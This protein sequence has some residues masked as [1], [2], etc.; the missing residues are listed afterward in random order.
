MNLR[1]PLHTVGYVVV[2]D[3]LK[4]PPDLIIELQNC[5]H[6]SSCKQSIFNHDANGNGNDYLRRQQHLRRYRRNTHLH[7]I[8]CTLETFIQREFSL[9][10]RIQSPILLMS[11]PGCQSQAP[12]T[13]F[14]T[15]DA[16][17]Q[18]A[19]QEI[20]LSMIVAL[21][22]ETVFDIYENSIRKGGTI[23]AKYR[24]QVRMR[25]GDIIVFRG[26]LVHGGSAYST[27]NVRLFYYVDSPFF[28]RIPNR[29]QFVS[30]NDDFV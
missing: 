24:K 9:K 26:D 13:D 2:S 8:Q 27:S 5:L 18:L 6:H 4:I 19:D 1:I 28:K 3:R 21:E 11:L 17:E 15:T 12:H 30:E 14:L 23:D 22:D 25:S 20:P 7:H 29:T 10:H 16:F